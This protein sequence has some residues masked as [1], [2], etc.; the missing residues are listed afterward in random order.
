VFLTSWWH[1]TSFFDAS[2][3]VIL[4]K[5]DIK[6][7]VSLLTK[8]GG[9]MP[10]WT[11]SDRTPLAILRTRAGLSRNEAAVK[12]TVGLAT[13]GRYELG[14]NDVPMG[15]AERMATLYG[16]SFDEIRMAVAKMKDNE[17]EPA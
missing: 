13:L 9:R 11:D 12:M 3:S 6:N 16:V 17:E 1:D 5:K 7:K 10:R 15:I 8:G 2:Q 4:L 14:I